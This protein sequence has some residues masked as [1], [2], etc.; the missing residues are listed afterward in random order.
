MVILS[1]LFVD[2]RPPDTFAPSTRSARADCPVV[3]HARSTMDPEIASFLRTFSENVDGI[4]AHPDKALLNTLTVVAGEFLQ[5]S[6][7][8]AA[9]SIASM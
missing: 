3:Y 9:T 8:I 4:K 5:N 1:V 2:E 7:P 6:G